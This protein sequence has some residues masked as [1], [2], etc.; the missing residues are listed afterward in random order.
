MTRYPFS[1]FEASGTA[2]PQRLN[3]YDRLTSPAADPVQALVKSGQALLVLI[4]AAFHTP[5]FFCQVLTEAPRGALAYN[6][7]L[8]YTEARLMGV[9]T[10]MGLD[11]EKGRY[12]G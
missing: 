10:T 11:R 7:P 5:L 9:E 6:H 1:K 12:N 2:S 3:P 4:F 8:T